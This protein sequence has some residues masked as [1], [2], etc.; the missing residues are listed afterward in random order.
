MFGRKFGLVEREISVEN[1]IG[2]KKCIVG[3]IPLEHTDGMT[4]WRGSTALSTF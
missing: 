3:D 4:F 2:S 1:G